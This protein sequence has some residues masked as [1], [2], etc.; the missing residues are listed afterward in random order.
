VRRNFRLSSGQWTGDSKG[1]V[2]LVAIGKT[3]EGNAAV[4]KYLQ[5]SDGTESWRTQL[6]QLTKHPP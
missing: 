3:H 6:S 1:T 5:R 4:A 2:H